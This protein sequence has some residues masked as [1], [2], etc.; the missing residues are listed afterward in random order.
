M[1]PRWVATRVAAILLP[2]AI[3]LLLP[4]CGDDQ[5][6]AERV[7][8]A[9]ETV[10]EGL[11]AHSAGNLEEAERLYRDAIED[12]DRN[13]FAYYNL[14]LVEQTTERPVEAEEHYRQAIEIDPNFTAALFNLAILRTSAG[15]TDEAMSLYEQVIAIDPGNAAAHLNLGFLHQDRGEE[16]EAE[17]QFDAAVEIDPSIE[18]RI[19]ERA[20]E[21]P[22]PE[23][24]DATGG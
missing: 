13:A 17:R 8:A 11:A 7:Q 5:S 4:A 10:Q 21:E 15:A 23:E 20:G 14:A 3:V 6:E 24:P 9:A 19:P 2:V 12:D 1:S 22:A 18:S 16:Q